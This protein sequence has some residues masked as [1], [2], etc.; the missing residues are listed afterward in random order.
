MRFR[1]VRKGGRYLRV[2]D[3][4]WSDPLDPEPSMSGGGRWNPP[5]S[6]PVTYLVSDIA[7]ARS[8]VDARFAGQPFDVLD[9]RTE[10]AP[11]L[12]TTGIP[13]ASFVDVLSD[14]GCRAAGF[15]VTYP[16]D[17]GWDGTQPVGQRAWDKGE[18]GIACR[19]ATP[20]PS[21]P[22]GAHELAWFARDRKLEIEDRRGFGS[23]FH[24]IADE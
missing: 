15:P 5:G 20:S 19:S 3:P 11:V 14:G 6:F 7:L 9:L 22:G 8:F 2:A 21:A 12:I 13:A 24:P 23:W 18:A 1:H 4:R 16:A 17:V 10:T